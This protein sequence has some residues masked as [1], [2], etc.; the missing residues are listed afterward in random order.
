MIPIAIGTHPFLKYLFKSFACVLD[1]FT[2]FCVYM[3][4][5]SCMCRLIKIIHRNHCTPNQMAGV[6]HVTVLFTLA[7]EGLQT[8]LMAL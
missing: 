1:V 5:P 6:E 7:V 2:H 8:F 3:F 4:V